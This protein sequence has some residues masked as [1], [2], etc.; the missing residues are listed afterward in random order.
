M[1]GPDPLTFRHWFQP[2]HFSGAGPAVLFLGSRGSSERSEREIF[3]IEGETPDHLTGASVSQPQRLSRF[4]ADER[5]ER[6]KKNF[7]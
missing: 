6:A 1:V 4:V 7:F 3:F 2:G 5:A